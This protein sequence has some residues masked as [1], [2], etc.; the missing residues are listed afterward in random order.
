MKGLFLLLVWISLLPL[1]LFAAET[2]YFKTA[3]LP[4]DGVYALL[5]RYNLDRYPCN[6][7]A[8]Y[9]INQLKS[10]KHLL[11]GK[12]YQLPI[13]IYT[14][15][16]KS[17]RSTLGM[18]DWDKA[19]RI[20]DYN[21]QMFKEGLRQDVFTNSKILW[22]PYHELHCADNPIAI[23]DPE[24]DNIPDNTPEG[25][26][27]KYDIFGSKYAFTPLKS[28][29]LKNKV[30]FVVSGHGGP[31][32]GAMSSRQG[33]QLCED[34]YAYDVALRFCRLLIEHGATAYMI[35]RDPNDGIRDA[36][37]LT[38]DT[39]ETVWPNQVIPN[40][41]IDRLTQRST[42][43]NEISESHLAKGQK[44]QIAIIIHVDSRTR[45]QKTDVFFYHHPSSSAGKVQATAILKAINRKY[46]RYQPGRVYDGTVKARD[47]HMLRE[48]NIPAVYVELA[49]IRNPADQI[50]IVETRNR[51]LLAEWMLDAF[52]QQN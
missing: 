23:A 14:Y 11:A 1:S 51:Q 50:R 30:F 22:V 34:E 17:I 46:S 29:R 45:S 15:N 12:E 20:Q 39:D 3:A 31:D 2:V 49:N 9:R 19:L 8:F 42:I 5:R 16:G 52:L 44:D 6:F 4:G 27:R 18:N 28:S 41:Q 37:F 35:T 47:L 10:N 21:N 43:I 32:P 24:P 13:L 7:E 25:T 36:G 26:N 48:V 38:C 40:G 33:K